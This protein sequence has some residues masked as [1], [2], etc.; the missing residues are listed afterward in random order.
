MDPRRDGEVVLNRRLAEKADKDSAILLR[1]K[2]CAC[3]VTMWHKPNLLHG[4]VDIHGKNKKEKGQEK[5]RR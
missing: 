5:E 1:P 4:K 2:A 3:L